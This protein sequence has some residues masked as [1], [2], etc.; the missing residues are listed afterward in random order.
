M[1][2]L[3]R[4]ILTTLAIL[5]VTNVYGGIQVD[6]VTTAVIAAVALGLIN[7]VVRP[8][9]VFLTLPLSILTLGLFLLIVNA[10]MLYLTAWLISGFDVGGF[11]DA[12]IASLIISVVV[13]LLNGLIRSG[14]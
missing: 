2:M 13:S 6:S 9:V 12:L 10:C 14:S 4:L 11:W 7:T 8:V 3:L 5:L 1:T